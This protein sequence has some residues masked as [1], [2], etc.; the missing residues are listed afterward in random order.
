RGSNIWRY[1]PSETCYLALFSDRNPCS[2]LRY[3]NTDFPSG[4]ATPGTICSPLGKLYAQRTPGFTTTSWAPPPRG[5]RSHVTSSIT[6]NVGRASQIMPAPRLYVGSCGS[7]V[8][9]A[10]Q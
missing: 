4:N 1:G 6:F 5:C 3:K 2:K 8:T 9:P 10:F 7:G